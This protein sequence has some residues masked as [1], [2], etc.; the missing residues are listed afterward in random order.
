MP[1]EAAAALMA[2]DATLAGEPADPDYAGLAELALILRAD[3]PVPGD[4]FGAALDERVE[5]RFARPARPARSRVPRLRGWLYGPAAG[6]AAVAAVVLVIVLVGHSGS[7]STSSEAVS[8]SSSAAA[9][10]SAPAPARASASNGNLKAASSGSAASASSAGSPALAPAPAPVD[11][12]KR[13]IVQ[14]AQLQLSTSPARI[15][16]VAQQVFGVVASENGIVENSNVT[17]T[18]NPNGNADFQLSVPSANL[19][20]TLN[21]LSALHGANVVSRSD[22]TTDITGQVGGAGQ[23]LAEARALRRSLLKQLA[24]AT[25][26]TQVDSI[27]IQLRDA[28]ASIASDLATLRKLQH[29]VAY[30]QVAV[31]IQASGAAGASNGSSFTLGRAVHDAG[32]VL[33]I[34]AGGALI[35]LAV[36]V[37][38]GLVAVLL[39]WVGLA[40]RRHR[41]EQVLDLV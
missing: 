41:R 36:L 23:R 7:S 40:I 12:G 10:A 24:G 39:A 31:T 28:D 25:T 6:L 30:S 3:R 9:T 27:R 22:A 33:V 11:T 17:A 32:R 8:S 37:P 13:Q 18:G 38:V 1:P 35:A 21:A 14:S 19:A 2:M 15:D 34:V 16:D 20:Q 26:T 5:R 4:R 29:Q